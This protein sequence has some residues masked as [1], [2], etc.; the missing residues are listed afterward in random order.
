MKKKKEKISSFDDANI[1]EG[2]F[3]DEDFRIIETVYVNG[4]SKYQPQRR[5]ALGPFGID[6]NI[7]HD[8]G[9]DHTSIAKAKQAIKTW[10]WE[11]EVA[12]TKI[13]RI[14]RVSKKQVSSNNEVV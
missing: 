1:G 14:G 2:P 3:T 4:D 7:W 8:I 6:F 13:H 11:N 12:E 9:L 10:R 5:S